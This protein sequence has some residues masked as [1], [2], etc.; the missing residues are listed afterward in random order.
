MERNTMRSLKPSLLV[1]CLV[2]GTGAAAALALHAAQPSKVAS[3]TLASPIT[4]P[5]DAS[6]E[7]IRELLARGS[8]RAH[9]GHV[10]CAEAL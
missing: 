9:R 3:L 5:A 4:N 8:V 7:P 1:L 10:A 6:M 2:A